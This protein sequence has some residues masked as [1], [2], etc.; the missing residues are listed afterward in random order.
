MIDMI[1]T[2]EK[3]YIYIYIYIY[4]TQNGDLEDDFPF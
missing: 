3:K 4:G 1:Y 2:L